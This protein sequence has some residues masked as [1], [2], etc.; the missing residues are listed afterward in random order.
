MVTCTFKIICIYCYVYCVLVIIKGFFGLAAWFWVDGSEVGYTVSW[1]W[2]ESG[3]EDWVHARQSCG[4][5]QT[6]DYSWI[7]WKSYT[8]QGFRS[9]V[10]EMPSQS[11]KLLLV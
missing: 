3:F 10:C 9:P 4:Y 1:D 11:P 2:A 8:C 7:V 5:I 6:D